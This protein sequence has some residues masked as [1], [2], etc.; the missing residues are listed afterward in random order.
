MLRKMMILIMQKYSK[1]YQDLSYTRDNV[2]I[3]S[4]Y[5]ILI[6]LPFILL[7]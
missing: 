2:Y 7:Y 5:P 1:I 3:G 4:V 6:L